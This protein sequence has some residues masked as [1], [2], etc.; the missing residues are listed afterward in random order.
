[1]IDQKPEV[2][3]ARGRAAVELLDNEELH[4]TLAEARRRA[5]RD[6]I[7]ASGPEALLAAQ[8]MYRAVDVVEAILRSTAAQGEYALANGR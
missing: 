8:A 7:E 3:I 6:F 1:M 5:T 2:L 4:A